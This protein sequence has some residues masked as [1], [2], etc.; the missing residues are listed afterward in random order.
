MWSVGGW[1]LYAATS[2]NYS[3]VCVSIR[4]LLPMLAPA[5]LFLALLLRERPECRLD[6]LL[7][8]A[9][10]LVW[11]AAAW[12]TGPWDRPA[13]PLFWVVVC[14][15]LI[16]WTVLRIAIRVAPPKTPPEFRLASP[17]PRG[18][19]TAPVPS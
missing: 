13:L 12:W 2:N 18:S 10:S 5:Y 1:L 8:S 9:W 3:G 6:L 14:G 17:D 4:W 15:G 7:L 16:C 19:A 11:A